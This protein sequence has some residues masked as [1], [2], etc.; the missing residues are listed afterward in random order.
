MRIADLPID[1][2]RITEFTAQGYWVETTSNDA[3][4]RLAA[5]V[6]DKRGGLQQQRLEDAKAM[7]QIFNAEMPWAAAVVCPTFVSTGYPATI[8]AA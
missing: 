5:E 6:P 2:A 8:R 3:F 1:P 4:G 7:A